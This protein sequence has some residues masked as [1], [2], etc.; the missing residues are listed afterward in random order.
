MFPNGFSALLAL[1]S[2]LGLV[3]A[4]TTNTFIYPPGSADGSSVISN[5]T[6]KIGTIVTLSW[7]T[8]FP[9]ITLTAF[10]GLWQGVYYYVVLLST[11]S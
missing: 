6:F 4:Q 1:L 8:D 10:Q 9:N 2:H 11:T 7:K 5:V 3:I